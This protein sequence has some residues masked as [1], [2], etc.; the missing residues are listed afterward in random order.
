MVKP[1]AFYYVL[2]REMGEFLL[3]REFAKQ[4]WTKGIEPWGRPIVRPDSTPSFEEWDPM[5][6]LST[7]VALISQPRGDS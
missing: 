1:N 3:A 7:A 2:G 4:S 5:H 6:V